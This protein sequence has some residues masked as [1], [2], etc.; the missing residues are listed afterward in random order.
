MQNLF[1]PTCLEMY[2]VKYHFL[3]IQDCQCLDPNAPAPTE[4]PPCSHGFYENDPFCD[5]GNNIAEC[6]FDGGACCDQTSP[7]WNL[8]CAVRAYL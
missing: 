4:A 6:N 8:F 1:V 3:L 7:F 2:I 5:D